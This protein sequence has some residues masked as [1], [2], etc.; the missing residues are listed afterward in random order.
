MSLA[1]KWCGWKKDLSNGC[2]SEAASA[3][4]E[5]VPSPFP[6]VLLDSLSQENSGLILNRVRRPRRN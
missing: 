4:L 3:W 2:G 1:P 6:S 5:K